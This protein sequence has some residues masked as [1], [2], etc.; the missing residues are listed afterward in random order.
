MFYQ[1]I[2][3]N[4]E[5]NADNDEGASWFALLLPAREISRL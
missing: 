5:R 3:D 4:V 1:M 2:K